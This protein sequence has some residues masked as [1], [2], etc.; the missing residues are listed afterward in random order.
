MLS[1]NIYSLLSTVVADGPPR[2]PIPMADKSPAR[3]LVAPAGSGGVRRHYRGRRAGRVVQARRQRAR[4]AEQRC[5]DYDRAL[6]PLSGPGLAPGMGEDPTAQT[7][8]RP[9]PAAD[10]CWRGSGSEGS[11]RVDSHLS[12]RP[13]PHS[14][15]VPANSTT[16]RHAG[17]PRPA[18]QPHRVL[19]EPARL[20]TRATISA[21]RPARTTRVS[22]AA[23]D[24]AKVTIGHLNVRSLMP[25]LDEVNMFLGTH[26]IDILCLSETWLTA[27]IDDRYTPLQTVW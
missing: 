22:A 10:G 18:S 4:N 9:G 11:C 1:F 23:V 16:G 12:R 14:A 7:R 13:P 15:P 5:Q 17:L 24:G 20:S 19:L 2:L 3:C 25:S 6:I 21:G 8:D 27:A 26:D